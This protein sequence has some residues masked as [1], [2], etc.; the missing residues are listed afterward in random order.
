MRES[1]KFS[2]CRSHENC[3]KEH[4]HLGKKAERGEKN[5]VSTVDSQWSGESM[6]HW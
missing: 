5:L 4:C 1:I 2:S 3:L 6:W